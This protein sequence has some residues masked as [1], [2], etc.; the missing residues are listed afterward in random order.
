M[1][2]RNEAKALQRV[3]AHFDEV[4]T[5]HDGKITPSE[6]LVY[7]AAQCEQWPVKTNGYRH[8]CSWGTPHAGPRA[9]L[10]RTAWIE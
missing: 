7:F 10:Q 4:D 2:S 6:I 1:L 5:N 8:G 9:A 3:S